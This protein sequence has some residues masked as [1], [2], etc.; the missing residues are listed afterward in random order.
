MQQ[1]EL[2]LADGLLRHVIQLERAQKNL[3]TMRSLCQELARTDEQLPNLDA[4]RWLAETERMEQEEGTQFVNIRKK[5]TRKRYVGPV[6]AA[7]VFVGLM[8]GIIGLI[9]WAI[10]LDPADAPPLWLLLILIAVPS[11]VIVGVLLALWQRLKQIQ[12]GEEDA[13]S[14]Y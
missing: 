11:A 7:A 4:G 13:A 6:V 12:G 5:D 9:L 8:A 3:G 1:G 2:T 14:K 10:S